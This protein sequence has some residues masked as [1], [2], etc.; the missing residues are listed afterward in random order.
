MLA[1]WWH[2]ES[3]SLLASKAFPVV[4]GFASIAMPVRGWAGC[5]LEL[6]Q[7]NLWHEWVQLF[8][9]GLSHC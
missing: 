7:Q 8:P 3:C 9:G 2:L 6:C 4:R 1:D 5:S